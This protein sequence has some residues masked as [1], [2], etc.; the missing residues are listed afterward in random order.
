MAIQ[1]A[2]LVSPWQFNQ[3]ELV[4]VKHSHGFTQA[5]WDVAPAEPKGTIVFVHG[6]PSSKFLFRHL[7]AG[8]SARYRCVAVDHIGMGDSDKPDRGSYDFHFDQRVDDLAHFLDERSVSG[9]ITLVVHDWGGVIGLRY[10][11]RHPER[12]ARLVISNTAAFPLLPGKKLPKEIAF[13]RNTWLGGFLCRYANAFQRGAVWRGV[14][15]K[16]A[17]EIAKG[18]LAAHPNAHDCEA[19]LRFVRDIPIKPSERGYDKLASLEKFLPSLAHLPVQLAWGLQDFVFDKD[20]LAEFQRIFP[21]A[22]SHAYVDAGHWL[23]EDVHDQMLPRLMA[24]LQ[25]TD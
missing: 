4:R 18:Y 24:F 14:V 11:Q 22:E 19:I 8:A 5:G 21:H 12:I 10:A 25:R 20:Y 13:V 9:K 16:M 3:A 23:Y 2:P 15:G 17:P 6:N 1:P 7:I